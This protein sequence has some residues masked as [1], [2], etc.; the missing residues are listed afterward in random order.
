MR[1]QGGNTPSST[2]RELI[3]M[4][5]ELQVGET[6]CLVGSGDAMALK[7]KLFGLPLKEVKTQL[8]IFSKIASLGAAGSLA[9]GGATV[10]D[11]TKQ[12]YAL[13]KSVAA[14]K[15]AVDRD[16]KNNIL[17]TEN[18]PFLQLRAHKKFATI[19]KLKYSPG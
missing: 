15:A 10:D 17:F 9:P 14:T 4:R 3:E 6:T 11:G 19:Q 8:E 2:V 7:M 13:S 16:A 1:G 5:S 18:S 12:I